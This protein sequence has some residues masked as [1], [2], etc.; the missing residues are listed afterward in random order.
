M[1]KLK[2]R[3]AILQQKCQRDSSVYFCKENGPW[4]IWLSDLV[5]DDQHNL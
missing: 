1:S 3:Y 5:F 4:A 2:Q